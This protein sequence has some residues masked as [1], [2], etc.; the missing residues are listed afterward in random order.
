MRIWHA[1]EA[2]DA[3]EL[4]RPG[5]SESGFARERSPPRGRGSRRRIIDGQRT[6]EFVRW[7][8]I[9]NIKV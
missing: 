7:P 6:I 2:G 8:F 9:V 1:R 4:Q 5:R 3:P